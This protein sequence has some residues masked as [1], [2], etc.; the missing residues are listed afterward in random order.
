MRINLDAHVLITDAVVGIHITH[1][2]GTNVWGT[3]TKRRAFSIPR[4]HGPSPVDLLIDSLPLPEGT[5]HLTVA[6]SDH[7]EVYP[8]DHWEERIRF[9]LYQ[10]D[11]FDAGTVQI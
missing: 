8:F 11:T 1:L 5:Y 9:N 3:K 2:H 4:I 7:A 10:H 6:V